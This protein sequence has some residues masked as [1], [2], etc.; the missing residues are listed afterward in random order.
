MKKSFFLNNFFNF[1]YRSRESCLLLD[2]SI[3]SINN[4]KDSFCKED[5]V[6]FSG[7]NYWLNKGQ[8]FEEQENDFF[9]NN[10]SG[11]EKL[12]SEKVKQNSKEFE[13]LNKSLANQNNYL[14]SLRSMQIE[15]FIAFDVFNEFCPD[16]SSSVSTIH[17][18][19]KVPL[20]EVEDIFSEKSVLGSVLPSQKVLLINRTCCNL[21][22]VSGAY[23][24]LVTFNGQKLCPDKPVSFRSLIQNYSGALQKKVGSFIDSN[25]KEFQN[26]ITDLADH[27]SKLDNLVRSREDLK[28][29]SRYSKEHLRFEKSS[30]NSYKIII[31]VPPYVIKRGGNYY[32]FSKAEVD[33]DLT[34]QGDSVCVNTKPNLYNRPY[35]HPFIWGKRDSGMCFGDLNWKDVISKDWAWKTYYPISDPKTAKKIALVLQRGQQLLTSSY[36][37]N[38]EGRMNPVSDIDSC[39]CVKTD[40]RERLSYLLKQKGIPESRVYNNN[41]KR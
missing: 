18:K 32:F 22:P 36:R 15:E 28:K 26:A 35:S 1:F 6:S 19:S 31:T 29:K 38:K 12:I 23:D 9:M 2:G 13:K 10:K 17:S 40:S 14:K 5:H 41:E 16:E 37:Y 3:Y 4:F 7:Q 25:L 24:L 27:K 30:S 21:K 8:S 33:I 20:P 11:L 34:A 39:D